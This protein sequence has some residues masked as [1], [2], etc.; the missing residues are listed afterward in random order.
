MLKRLF[1][2]LISAF[3]L[4]ILSPLLFVIS[5]SVLFF[6]GLP[7]LFRQKRMGLY[8]REFIL[9]KFRTMT[10][11]RGSES[12]TFDAGSVVRVTRLGHFLRRTKLDELPQLW[13]VLVGDMSLVGPRPEVRKWTEVYPERWAL[14]LSV[15]PGITDPASIVFRNEENLLAAASDPENEYRCVILPRKL[16][17]YE[18]YLHNPTFWGDLCILFRTLVAL[19]RKK[20]EKAW[21][22]NG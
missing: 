6:D 21:R 1:D 14:V 13:N 19:P 10:V 22:K 16:S 17:L 18:D 15:K 20:S 11:R 8:G 3:G 2:I 5:V 4:M 12:G 7:I 9:L